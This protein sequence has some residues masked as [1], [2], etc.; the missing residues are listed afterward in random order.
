MKKR[1]FISVLSILSVIIVVT[2]LVFCSFSKADNSSKT[3]R[4]AETFKEIIAA[5]P[6]PDLTD[7]VDRCKPGVDWEFSRLSFYDLLKLRDVGNSDAV[8]ILEKVMEDNLFQTRIHGFA[9][10]E[11]L[12]CIDTEWAHN[13]LKKYLYDPRYRSGLGADYAFH[14][15]MSEPKRSEFI[16][17]Y[18]LKNLSKELE[19]E[20]VSDVNRVNTEQEFELTLTVH[21]VSKEPFRILDHIA[22]YGENIYFRNTDGLFA[23]RMRTATQC[24]KMSAKW[25]EMKPA[26]QRRYKI[27]LAV[28]RVSD[29]KYKSRYVPENARIYLRAPFFDFYINQPAKFEIYAMFEAQPLHPEQKKKLEFDNEWIGRAVSKSITI[30]ITNY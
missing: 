11:A 10:A 2:I 25:L 23:R 27:K 26:D 6:E 18:H 1:R 9:A 16:R 24:Y 8:N 20:L 15:D 17:Q 7:L 14:W 3:S 28:L 12:F 13:V 19:L 5:H 29:M 22:G 30:E 4:R 21:N